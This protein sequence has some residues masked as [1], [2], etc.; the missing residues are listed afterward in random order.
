M[1]AFLYAGRASAMGLY[2]FKDSYRMPMIA[3]FRIC[4]EVEGDHLEDLEA[5]GRYYWNGS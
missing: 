3:C 1:S 5:D 4:Y 2:L